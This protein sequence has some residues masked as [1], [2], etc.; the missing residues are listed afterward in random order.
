MSDKPELRFQVK[1]Q[2]FREAGPALY[3]NFL[4]VSRVGTDVQFEFVFLDL[5]VIA[6]MMKADRDDKSSLPEVTGKTVAKLV[7]PAAVVVQMKEHLTRII[8]DIENEMAKAREAQ[9]EY[10]RTR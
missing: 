5:N 9:N 4:A 3:S 2:D 8:E 10:N 7:V 6:T 1:G